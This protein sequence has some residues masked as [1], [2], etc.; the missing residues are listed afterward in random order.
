MKE[1]EVKITRSY[2]HA[3]KG[4]LEWKE[5]EARRIRERIIN[6]RRDQIGAL[7]YL[8]G[9][10]FPRD[11]L[12]QI[13]LEIKENGQNSVNIDA[14]VYEAESKEK[15]LWWLDYFERRNK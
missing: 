15:L 4:E 10:E 5:S 14:I 2:E 3:D 7:S 13:V 6:L 1:K 8:I 9:V 11:E 12:D